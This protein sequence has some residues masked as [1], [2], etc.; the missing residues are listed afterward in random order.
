MTRLPDRGA[1][2]SAAQSGTLPQL[3]LTQWLRLNTMSTVFQPPRSVTSAGTGEGRE[4][5]GS[6][7]GL[8]AA[9]PVTDI[10]SRPLVDDAVPEARS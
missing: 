2:P 5:V 3:V 4:G 9:V 7:P 8:C 10:H 6:A 1:L